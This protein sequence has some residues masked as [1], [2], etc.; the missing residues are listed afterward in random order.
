MTQVWWDNAD[1]MQRENRNQ[2]AVGDNNQGNKGTM[3]ERGGEKEA[4]RRAGLRH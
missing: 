1:A 4:T 3:R 2:K